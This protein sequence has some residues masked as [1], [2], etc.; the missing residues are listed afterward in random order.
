MRKMT[1]MSAIKILAIFANGSGRPTYERNHHKSQH[2]NPT[3][4]SV[5][6]ALTSDEPV[7]AAMMSDVVIILLLS[8][9]A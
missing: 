6:K 8:P 4:T 7:M 1:A 3:T 5:I 9:L 2:I